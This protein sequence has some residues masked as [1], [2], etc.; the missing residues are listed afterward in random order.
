M[1][2]SKATVTKIV[3]LLVLAF[4]LFGGTGARY[5]PFSALFGIATALA[6]AGAVVWGLRIMKTTRADVFITR[7]FSVFWPLY[8]LLAAAGIGSW[9]WLSVLIW[10]FVI[11]MTIVE[12][13]Y[14]LTWAKSLEPETE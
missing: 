2:V 7:T 11:W 4:P 8:L 12:N 10:P 14:F 13:H 9:E 3:W 6:A 5:H 1:R